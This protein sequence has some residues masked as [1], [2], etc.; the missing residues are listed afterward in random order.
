MSYVCFRDDLLFKVFMSLC[1]AT[2]FVSLRLFESVSLSCQLFLVMSIIMCYFIIIFLHFFFN[3]SLFN[4]HERT[5]L[6]WF[7]SCSISFLYFTLHFVLTFYMKNYF[8]DCHN[9]LELILEKI[10]HFGTIFREKK[11]YTKIY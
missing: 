6:S 2:S 1:V 4:F 9:K 10:K 5:K 8:N 11:N 3:S 7:C